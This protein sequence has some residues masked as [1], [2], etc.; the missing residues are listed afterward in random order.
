MYNL[1][2][3]I[4]TSIDIFQK[5]MVCRRLNDMD[6]KVAAN[7]AGVLRLLDI[8]P[9]YGWIGHRNEWFYPTIE[10]VEM[11]EDWLFQCED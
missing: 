11:Q 6:F 3:C 2:D 4:V 5:D 1:N 7:V 8:A 9:Q 10:D